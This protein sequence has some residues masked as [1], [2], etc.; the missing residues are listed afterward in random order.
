MSTAA[1]PKLTDR[2]KE[3]LDY[4]RGYDEEYGFPPSLR[5][6]ANYFGIRSTNGV[7]C[8]LDAIEKKGW[9][10]RE[11]NLSRAI[12]LTDGSKPTTVRVPRA[13]LKRVLRWMDEARDADGTRGMEVEYAEIVQRLQG[14]LGEG[15]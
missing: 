1:R 10:T 7:V 12:R 3:I 13:L 11:A 4:I 5:E 15:K 8:T 14:L 2:Q 9:L 6:I